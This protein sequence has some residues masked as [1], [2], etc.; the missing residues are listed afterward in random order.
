MP[1][2]GKKSMGTLNTC[3]RDIQTVLNEAI[4]HT[5]FSVIF[6]NRTIE[7]QQEL[8]A[9]GR[10]DGKVTDISKV[11]T[12]LDGVNKKSYHQSGRALDFYAYVDGKAS[13]EK[14]HLAVVACS[15][16]QAANELGY[17]LEW[18]GLWKSFQD[19]PHVQLSR[20]NR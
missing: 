19:M 18:G 2:F 6:G 12:Y 3:E 8:Y 5:D 14:E 15:F 11:V 17:K 16:L 20:A 1:Y 7:L 13:W 4:K 10:T 9:K